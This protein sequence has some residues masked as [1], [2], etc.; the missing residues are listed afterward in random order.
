MK[1][2]GSGRQYVARLDSMSTDCGSHGSGLASG[3]IQCPWDV[4]R[5]L[6]R[7]LFPRLLNGENNASSSQD[8]A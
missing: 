8:P 4:H 7:T 6:L 2:F 3:V 5:L 1:T